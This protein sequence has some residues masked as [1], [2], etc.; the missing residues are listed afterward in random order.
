MR[1]LSLC[2][3]RTGRSAGDAAITAGLAAPLLRD[4]A[5]RLQVLETVTNEISRQLGAALQPAAEGGAPAEQQLDRALASLE[6]L[7]KI[8]GAMMRRMDQLPYS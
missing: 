8:A 5:V 4:L 6:R 2:L 1:E 7:E 3:D